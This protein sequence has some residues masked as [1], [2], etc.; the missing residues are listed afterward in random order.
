MQDRTDSVEI[1]GEAAAWAARCVAGI[2][3]ADR[4]REA[5]DG[6]G[7]GDW[8]LRALVGHTSRAL[9]TVR[10]AL[11]RPAPL[12]PEL[13]GPEDYFLRV[14][15]LPGADPEAVRLRGVE[16]G[17]ALGP[18]PAAAFAKLF[19]ETLGA[20]R[21]AGDPVV[22]TIG[23]AMR[24]QHYLVTRVFELVVHGL[25]ICAAA[26]LADPPPPRALDAALQLAS[27][28]ALLRGEGADILLAVTGRA[29]LPAGFSVLGP[30]R[31]GA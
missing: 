26:G 5:W 21:A 29:P 14:S 7:L 30:A 9:A 15:S 27:R 8:D 2:G 10:E 6:A 24:L 18:A 19:A 25:D 16:A 31:S 17:S 23:G 22:G 11:G 12:A 13:A 1:F 3:G 28:L 4:G 20:V